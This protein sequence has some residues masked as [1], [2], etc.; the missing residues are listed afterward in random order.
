[1]MEFSPNGSLCAD[2]VAGVHHQ[3]PGCE[4]LL[5]GGG[6]GRCRDCL[7]T[8]RAKHLSG[9]QLERI[10]QDWCRTLWQEFFYWASEN[11]DAKRLF[12][13][14]FHAGDFFVEIDREFT[15]LSTINSLSLLETF[16]A[17]WLRRHMQ[18]HAFLVHIGIADMDDTERQEWVEGVRIQNYIE[19]VDGADQNMLRKYVEWCRKR[20]NKRPKNLTVRVYVR[21][22]IALLESTK[23]PIENLD[24][25]SIS[26]FLK[27]HKGQRA[28][29]TS[30]ITFLRETNISP[31][32][33]VPKKVK[34][35]RADYTNSLIEK[36]D[37]LLLAFYT[38]S[39]N[40]RR[41]ALGVA[42]IAA[43]LGVPKA[44]VVSIKVA[45]VTVGARTGNIQI[46]GKEYTV[47]GKLLQ[48]LGYLL[49]LADGSPSLFP[50]RLP[51][52]ALAISSVDYHIRKELGPL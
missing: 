24:E 45:G 1:M 44:H 39:S 48:V 16:G 15:K 23:T 32:A 31:N 52:D 14:L 18:C 41:R 47:E 28:S 6:K 7:Y 37:T 46:Q 34:K 19:G 21:A 49:Q 4:I 2:C 17:E 35:Y 22:A 29:L 10:E 40:A 5:P 38:T 11:I 30:F 51:G 26:G 8:A 25:K 42:L 9:L 20:K 12:N 50:G 43:F 33:R 13:G 3:C 27:R 36:I